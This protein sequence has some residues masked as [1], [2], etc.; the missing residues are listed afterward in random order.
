[1]AVGVAMK[2]AYTCPH[3]YVNA[4]SCHHV[5]CPICVCIFQDAPVECAAIFHRRIKAFM[6]QYIKG[7]GLLGHVLHY[8]IRYE[9]QNRGS[10]HAHIVLWLHKD[11]VDRVS[12]SILQCVP[13]LFV[14]ADGT[15]NSKSTFQVPA[16]ANLQTL[17]AIVLRKQMHSC[18]DVGAPGCREKGR[19]SSGFPYDKPQLHRG[20][21]YNASTQ[22]WEYFRPRACDQNVVPYHPLVLLYWNAHMNIQRITA[23]AWS[24]YLLK[25]A[26]K[27]RA[28]C[29]CL[30]PT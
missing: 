22:R 8:V 5:L 24:F 21:L 17:L 29:A 15:S 11:D 12:D 6:K 7:K 27:V 4:D 10:L 14:A 30:L 19:C 28:C 1:M 2:P 25:Y 20:A 23:S 13:A 16:D 9:V 26:C 18:K 3:M